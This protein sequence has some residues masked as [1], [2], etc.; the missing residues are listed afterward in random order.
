M[1]HDAAFCGM[2]VTPA[3]SGWIANSDGSNRKEIE[4][5][6]KIKPPH[7]RAMPASLASPRP[8]MWRLWIGSQR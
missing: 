4:R 6:K 2:Q 3:H 8:K 5:E 1:R 7:P